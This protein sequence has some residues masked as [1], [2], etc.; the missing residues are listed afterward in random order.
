MEHFV[1]L[2]RM[3]VSA[4]GRPNRWELLGLGGYVV[5]VTLV[6]GAGPDN[7][8]GFFQARETGIRL[9]YLIGTSLNM[10]ILLAT[11]YV[12]G[13]HLKRGGPIWVGLLVTAVIFVIGTALQTGWQL[14]LIAVRDTHLS[15]V[16]VWALTEVNLIG[17]TVTLMISLLY[18]AVRAW[19]VPPTPIEIRP[20]ETV[21]L[22]EGAERTRF[23]LSEIWYLKSAGNYLEVHLTGREVMV[24]G[25]LKTAM[26]ALPEGRFVQIHRSYVV[27]LD[28][29]RQMKRTVAVMDGGEL[30]VGASRAD[31]AQA[32]WSERHEG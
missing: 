27:N 20:E 22:G 1:K 4:A 13:P 31:A 11:V 32:S 21:M 19:V 30:P 14:I 12:A 25:S 18:L 15:D 10:A 2:V 24:Y 28:K 6:S 16:T 5:L 29:V 17:A 9:P 7:G 23:T 8:I 26:T 3:V